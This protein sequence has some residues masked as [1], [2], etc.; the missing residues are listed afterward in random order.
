MGQRASTS[1]ADKTNGC[2]S[3]K[4]VFRS[5]GL[6]SS[7]SWKDTNELLSV[8]QRTLL[9]KSW[10]KS[11]RTGLENIGAQVYLRIALHEPSIMKLFGIHDV[12]ISE[13]KYNKAFQQQSMTMTRS[14]DFIVKNLD[15]LHTVKEY[16][17]ELGYRH[18]KYASRGFKPEYWDIFAESLTECAIEWEAL[19]G[20]R[21][22]VRFLIEHMKDGFKM[23]ERE[24]SQQ[25][26]QQQQSRQQ[27]FVP[28]FKS[29]MS[30]PIQSDSRPS[31]LI[32][33]SDT[34]TFSQITPPS[35][36]ATATSRE[37]CVGARTRYISCC[38]YDRPLIERDAFSEGSRTR[39]ARSTN[40]YY[41]LLLSTS[42][43]PRNYSDLYQY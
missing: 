10:M 12:K 20:W 42:H 34:Q 24:Q 29:E 36:L 33:H 28:H 7:L 39:R 14:L 31:I 2:V 19:I 26:Q 21:M 8:R 13:L 6:N 17:R 11:Q 40:D 27:A 23:G 4:K 22:L 1:D 9:H 35:T 3:A 43:L 37:G 18:V 5:N 38:S 41:D 25:H 32:S 16:C 15:N 30:L